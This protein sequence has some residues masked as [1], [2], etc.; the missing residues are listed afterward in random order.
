MKGTVEGR[1]GG[2]MV[3]DFDC[4]VKSAT[5]ELK[6]V[7]MLDYIN[8]RQFICKETYPTSEHRSPVS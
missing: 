7:L 4:I 8:R 3:E 2:Q 5:L 6:A 1:C